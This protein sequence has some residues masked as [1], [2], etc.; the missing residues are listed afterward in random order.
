MN[1]VILI[2]LIIIFIYIFININRNNIVYIEAKSGC[3]FLVH[4][5]EFK[6]EK[7]SLLCTIVENMFILKNYLVENKNNF[8]EYTEYIK[9]LEK[10]FNQ[11][12]TAVYE[13]DPKSEFNII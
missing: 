1:E 10:N 8:T 12:K 7:A 5:D 3:K 11:T 4:E 2:I 13:T 6:N 9:Q